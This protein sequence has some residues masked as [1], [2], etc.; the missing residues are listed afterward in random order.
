MEAAIKLAG[1]ESDVKRSAD[2]FGDKIYATLEVNESKG[3]SSRIGWRKQL[4]TFLKCVYPVAQVSIQLTSSI[5]E[6]FPLLRYF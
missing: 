4:H 3:Q 5:A 1:S 2:L 6:V